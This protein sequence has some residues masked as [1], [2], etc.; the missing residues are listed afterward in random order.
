MGFFRTATRALG[1]ASLGALAWGL[2]VEPRWLQVVRFR[3]A[4]P[5]LPPAWEGKTVAVLS[6]FQVG[7]RGAGT[8]A[9]ERAVRRAVREDVDLA[10]FAGDFV[11]DAGPG[12]AERAAGLLRPFVEAG[13]PTY[14]VFGNHDYRINLL[15]SEPDLVLA[16]A[17]EA[18]AREV[19]VRV[20]HN[21]HV[22]LP[23][24]EGDPLY[25]V[26]VGSEW[27]HLADVEQAFEGLPDDAPRLVLLHHPATF[28][29]I[30]AH[31]APL[32]VAGH[33]HGGQVRLLPFVH[34][35]RA[36]DAAF[37]V[38]GWASRAHGA[39]GNRLYVNRGIG[40]SWMPMRI[41]ARPELTL[42]ELERTVSERTPFVEEVPEPD[43]PLD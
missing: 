19:G 5:N 17:V 24:P 8:T 21:K 26:G 30:P 7:C 10:L 6:D 22:E 34:E 15:N 32:A 39:E 4:I 16:G 36:L 25:L 20:L 28:L 3:I 41:G 11:Y 2:V 18:A 37:V 27:A 31:R 42:I 33:T 35:I 40:F 12:D 38:D 9:A 14:A 13:I 29:R 43:V 23:G 1:A